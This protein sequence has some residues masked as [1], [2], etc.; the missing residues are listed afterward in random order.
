MA[1]H[2]KLT[3]LNPTPREYATDTEPQMLRDG[4]VRLDSAGDH[5]REEL[6]SPWPMMGGRA[7]GRSR[8]GLA[9]QAY[10]PTYPVEDGFNDY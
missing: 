6:D 9:E 5:R 10:S 3:D 7:N 4:Y 8:Q 2:R 1:R